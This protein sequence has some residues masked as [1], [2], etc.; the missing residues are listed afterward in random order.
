MGALPQLSTPKVYTCRFP[1]AIP[2]LLFCLMLPTCLLKMMLVF[3]LLGGITSKLCGWSSGCCRYLIPLSFLVTMRSFSPLCAVCLFFAAMGA[4]CVV[5]KIWHMALHYQRV[6][7]ERR[8]RIRRE[9]RQHH[10]NQRLQ[11]EKHRYTEERRQT[12]AA[13]EGLATL[14]QVFPNATDAELF[15]SIKRSNGSVE[16]AALALAKNRK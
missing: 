12:E 14:R 2:C 6:R 11:R 10:Q 5:N 3:S 16:D 1:P 4:T 8:E 15:L 9:S 7:R 13:F